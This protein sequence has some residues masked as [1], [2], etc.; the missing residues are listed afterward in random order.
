MLELEYKERKHKAKIHF[1]SLGKGT[2]AILFFKIV[3]ANNL[4]NEIL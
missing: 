1:K 4:G 3:E 2:V